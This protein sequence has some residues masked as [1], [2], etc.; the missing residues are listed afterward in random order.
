MFGVLVQGARSIKDLLVLLI[1]VTLCAWLIDVGDKVI[2]SAAAIL[3]R[4][5]SIWSITSAVPVETTVV[6]AAIV[7]LSVVVA[8]VV[9]ANVVLSVVVAVVVA[10]RRAIS[11]RIF[12]KTH[13]RFLGIG[14]LVGG[15]DHLVNPDGRLAVELGAKLTVMESSDE[16]GDDLSFRD[17]GNR[18]PHLEKALNVATKE[19]RWLLVDAVEIMLGA[20]TS[21]RSHIIVG[22]DFF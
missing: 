9:A 2:W 4:F 16:G 7:V 17:V 8:V 21:T 3:T 15:C 13:L 14:I 19:L 22:E 12:V 6:V 20:W 5:E 1:V 10:A 11:A 18:V